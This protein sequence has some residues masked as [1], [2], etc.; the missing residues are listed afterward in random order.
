MYYQNSAMHPFLLRNHRPAGPQKPGQREGP[1]GL[2][3]N[4]GQMNGYTFS[5]L[6]TRLQCTHRKR[7]KVIGV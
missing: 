7:A 5:D 2:P 4:T 1:Q 3:I 6:S